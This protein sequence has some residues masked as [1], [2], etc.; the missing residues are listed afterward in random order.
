MCLFPLIVQ[1]AY[2]MRFIL[3]TRPIP[4]L[5]DEFPVQ[6]VCLIYLFMVFMHANIFID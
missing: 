6:K 2:S 4:F 3:L 1:T 5:A